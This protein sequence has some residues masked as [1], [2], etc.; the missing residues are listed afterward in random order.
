MD[1]KSRHSGPVSVKTYDVLP[2]ICRQSYTRACA[3]FT[4]F[5]TKSFFRFVVQVW[6]E[7]ALTCE[8]IPIGVVNPCDGVSRFFPYPD[9]PHKYIMCDDHQV[10]FV[11]PCPLN[12]VWDQQDTTCVP[13]FYT[14]SAITH[15][16]HIVTPATTQ[17]PIVIGTGGIVSR[18]F[19]YPCTRENIAA[20]KFYFAYAPDQ[21]KYIQCDLWGDAFLR[22]C[23]Q[24]FYFFVE[25]N[26]CV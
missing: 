15:V 13:P 25:S 7:S 9:D 2:V 20:N 10:P 12:F 16:Y 24:G 1:Y 11:M 23:Q 8:V 19:A 3:H 26:T 14:P 5:M 18:G 4:R 17:A 21:N 6:R 22:S